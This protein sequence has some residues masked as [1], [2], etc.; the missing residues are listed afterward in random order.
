MKVIYNDKFNFDLGWL[1]FIHPFDGIKFRR[2]YKELL[3]AVQVEIVSPS[4]PISMDIADEF[5]TTVC[6]GV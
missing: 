1:R 6:R 4:S 5:L 2:V 3:K